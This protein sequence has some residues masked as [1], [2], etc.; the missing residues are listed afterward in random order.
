MSDFD[1][2]YFENIVLIV[3]DEASNYNQ[4]VDKIG[5]SLFQNSHQ[6]YSAEEFKSTI[7]PYSDDQLI[8]FLVHIF[9]NED[10]KGFYSYRN[11][12]L[13]K[14]LPG[15]SAYYITSAPKRNMHES[16]ETF[17]AFSYDDFPA[18]V[19]AIFRPQKK[20]EIF[21]AKKDLNTNNLSK[22]GIFLSHSS[23]DENI[24]QKFKDLIL[25][26]GLSV[27]SND[28]KFTSREAGG[29]AGGINIPS[30]LHDFIKNRM[31]LFIQFLSSDYRASET[32]VN[33]EGAAWV[34]MQELMLVPVILKG[35]SSDDI[36]WIINT[37]KGIKIGDE[38][39]LM[40]IYQDRKEF[41]G[42]INITN[43]KGKI[44]EFVEFLK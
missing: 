28:I 3:W 26:N 37:H 23:K 40:N 2:E 39:S 12:G 32:C 8:L 10:R 36:A 38:D 15:L 17:V 11:S 16:N 9:H 4:E 34:L 7:E 14:D 6:V 5:V 33:E 18:E 27:N 35:A 29:I 22:K 30:D 20:S 1:Y 13:K 25:V 41:F 24:V 43:L 42:D 21:G 31:G 44:A 19:G